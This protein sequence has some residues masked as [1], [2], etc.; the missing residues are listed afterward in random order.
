M[1]VTYEEGRVTLIEY[2]NRVVFYKK[3]DFSFN[4]FSDYISLTTP[5][6]DMIAFIKI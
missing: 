4:E 2:L 6:K 3:H 5:H 1:F